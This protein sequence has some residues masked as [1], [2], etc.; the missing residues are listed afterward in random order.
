M[1]KETNAP[2]K[3]ELLQDDKLRKLELWEVSKE[4]D[5]FYAIKAYTKDGL[6]TIVRTE[7]P[8][9]KDM[10]NCYKIIEA[11]NERQKL[12]DSNCELLDALES[13][14]DYHKQFYGSWLVS[15]RPLTEQ[16][17]NAINNAKNIQP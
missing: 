8:L 7:T 2:T 11:V 17:K 1:K 16:I 12:L 13:Y 5:F 10:M 15:L 3:G 14:M 6:Q 9:K 4:T